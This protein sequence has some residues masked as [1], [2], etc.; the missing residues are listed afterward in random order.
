MYH[1][2]PKGSGVHNGRGVDVDNKICIL[3]SI[4]TAVILEA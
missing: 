3:G 1:G 4:A 2:L